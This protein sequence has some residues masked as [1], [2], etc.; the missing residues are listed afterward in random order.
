MKIIDFNRKGNVVRFYLGADDCENYWG[1]DWDDRP[2]E[3]NAGTVYEEFIDG[4]IDIAFAFGCNVLDAESDYTY[5][6]NSPFSKQDFKNGKA[7]CIVAIA[8][9]IV[10]DDYLNSDVYSRQ[11]G[12]KAAECFYFNDPIERIL[13]CPLVTVLHHYK[14]GESV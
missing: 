5:K 3:H 4:Y 14:K 6:G 10:E 1:D 9:T 13:Q 12:N 2:Y 11:I 8:E 7:P